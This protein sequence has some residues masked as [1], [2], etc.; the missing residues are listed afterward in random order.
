MADNLAANVLLGPD[1]LKQQYQLEQNK[2]IADMLMAKGMEQPQGQMVSGR[3]VAPSFFQNAAPLLN[4]YLGKQAMNALPQQQANIAEAQKNQINS[5]FGVGGAT[6]QQAATG[7]LQGGAMQGSTGPTM[8]NALRMN[9]VQQGTGSAM[10]I[11]AGMTPQMAAMQ[12]L[13]DPKA[14]ATALSSHSMPTNE[15]K[16]NEYLGIT[17]E[18]AKTFEIGKRRSATGMSPG[19]IYT[20]Q[21]GQMQIAPDLKSGMQGVI[22][23]NGNV[24]AFAIP[25]YA[26][27]I[28]QNKLAETRG[29]KQAESEYDLVDVID[30]KTNNT[31]QVP[32]SQVLGLNKDEQ[33]QTG[34]NP[35]YIKQIN[36]VLTQSQTGLNQEFIKT[37]LPAITARGEI[38][39][40][41]LNTLSVLKNLDFKTGWGTE[42]KAEAAKV[43][44]A[45]GVK[46]AEKYASNAQIFQSEASKQ[47][48]DTLASQK[49]P[50]TENDAKRAKSIYQ[51][52]SNTPDANQFIM[53]LAEA[54]YLQ[55]KRQADYYNKAASIPEM[56]NN[57]R[58]IHNR[59]NK[60]QGSIF[61]YPSM[62]KYGIK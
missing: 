46:D 38:A 20:N 13:V 53:D 51:S 15:Q 24:Q 44:G 11:P 6:P 12:Y 41:G 2:R 52:L 62:Q 59:W 22:D 34:V 18:T 55:D 27:I 19:T 14:Y 7:A 48:F 17:P 45:L 25:E 30:P 47:L 56:Q 32:R 3:Y 23:A 49:G 4:A 36:P 5:M 8:A 1:I 10:P 37:D 21:Q 29:S 26:N 50:Q 35:S 60:I 40:N 61:D 28:K 58:E 33:Q 57:L 16:V 42:T 9:N 43:L 31:I 54:K 39:Q